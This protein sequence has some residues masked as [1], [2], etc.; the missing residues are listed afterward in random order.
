MHFVSLKDKP[1]QMLASYAKFY[2][3]RFPEAFQIKQEDD[4]QDK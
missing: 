1:A 4:Q 2:Q 3:E